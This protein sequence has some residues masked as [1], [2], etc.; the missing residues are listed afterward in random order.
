MT[1]KF[2]QPLL[3]AAAACL[4]ALIAACGGGG[5]GVVPGG[6]SASS[7][8]NFVLNTAREWYL[9][10]ELL[11]TSVDINAYA[12]AEDLLDALTA[13]ARSQN[14][15]R[16]FSYL[17]TPAADS[18]FLQEGQFIGFG[19]RTQ[20]EGNRLL[21]PDVY[22][23]SPAAQGGLARGS[24]ITHVDGVAIATILQTDPNLEN[25]FGPP[26]E[27]VQRTLRFILV[28]GQQME[29]IFTKA[30]V[31]IP[32]V[33][34]N[35]TAVL[36]LPANPNVPVGYLNLRTFISTA[37]APLRGA[38]QQFRNLGI[39]NFIFDLRYNGGGLV[40]IADLVG[41]LFGGGRLATDVFENMRF[42]AS[43][44]ANDSTHRFIQ[45]PQSVMPVRIAFITTGA[46]ASASELVVNGMKPWVEVAIVG[47]DTY[48]KPVG[49]SAFDLAGCDLRLRLITFK[50]TNTDGEGDYFDGLAPTL[51]FACAAA[52]DLT[53]NPWDSAETSTAAALSWL[54]TGACGQVI[55]GVPAA[56]AFRVP[57]I[58]V[59]QMQRPTPAQEALPGLF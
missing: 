48:G 26:T 5:G 57:A 18:S 53:R 7:E 58:R 8:K 22:E 49:Q 45:Q 24:E 23:G 1:A 38:F 47:A 33:P 21:V 37:D 39:Q 43:K 27:G 25:A 12:T 35:G 59:P 56:P 55:S 10:P 31:T 51:A 32:P 44:S 42:N 50:I 13:T 17:T 16:F 14:K 41:D 3:S 11:P 28:G 20:I 30:I 46:T 2:R 36:A 19:F 54:Q 4:S 15:D 6:C 34:A 9:F 29:A 40:G 52:D